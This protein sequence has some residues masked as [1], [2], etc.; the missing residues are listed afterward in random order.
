MSGRI[1]QTETWNKKENALIEGVAGVAF[2]V[3]NGIVV[4]IRRLAPLATQPH[5]RGR[6]VH[7][8]KCEFSRQSSQPLKLVDRSNQPRPSPCQTK[9]QSP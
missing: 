2:V 8:P 7:S 1:E 6:L 9:K 3:A 4:G 5:S